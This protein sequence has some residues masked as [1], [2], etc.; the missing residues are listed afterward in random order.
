M[1]GLT[2]SFAYLR[3]KRL[4]SALNAITFAAGIA[5]IVALLLIN[6]QLQ[7]EF[8]KNLQGIDLVAGGKGSPL[9]LILSSVFDIDIPTGNIP[10]AEAEKL[11]TH[12]LIKSAIPVA[13]GDNYNG[14][15]IVGTNADYI[16]HYNGELARGAVFTKQMEAVLGSEVAEKYNLKLGN[17][18]IGAHGLVNSDDL[19]T[20]FPYTIVGILKPSGTVMDRLVLTPVESVW[21]VH[22]HPDADDPEEVAYKKAHP[23]KEVT[24]LLIG[25]KTPMAAASLPRIVNSST[26]MQAASPA[27]EV[28]RLNSFLG[29]G[30]DTLA[31]FGWLL[32]GLAGL[33]VFASLYNAMDERRYDLALMRSLGAGRRKLFALVMTE[34]LTIALVGSIC[35]LL[36]GH[37]LVEVAAAWLADTKHIHITGKLFLPEEPW[38]LLLGLLI[39]AASAI[40]PAVRVYRI[41]IFKT[42]VNR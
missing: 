3:H 41:D 26:S 22:E 15:R 29:M 36:L 28:A 30:T 19:H 2:L 37:G 42:L 39:G 7:N 23:E 6:A 4:S 34:S 12:P 20:D 24:A 18:I 10:L 25:Y 17:S 11:S 5:V 9:Q 1:N 16:S 32:M 38:L 14:F 27:F 40:I 13:L 8:T 31:T 35:G 33:G 21:H